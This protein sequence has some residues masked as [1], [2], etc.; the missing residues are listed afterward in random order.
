MRTTRRNALSLRGRETL[1]ALSAIAIVAFGLWIALGS[2]GREAPESARRENADRAIPESLEPNATADAGTERE[3]RTAPEPPALEEAGVPSQDAAGPPAEESASLQRRLKAAIELTLVG[4]LDPTAIVQA[5]S[6]LAQLHVAKENLPG[7]A[8]DGSLRYALTPC[9]RG[10]Q[11]EL[12]VARSSGSD[13][14][15]V[16]ALRMQLETPAEPYLVE[17]AVRKNPVAHVQMHL[18][19]EGRMKDLVILTDVAPSGRSGSFG[20][21]LGEGRIPQGILFHADMN[22]PSEWNAESYGLDGGADRSWDDPIA[23]LGDPWPESAGL[24]ELREG[25]LEL[26]SEARR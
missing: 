18:D 10:I 8:P 23:L 17:G 20:L 26:L 19:E 24:A 1:L 13:F 22:Q 11:A 6:S 3:T 25:L 7:T 15:N 4:A 14:E 2:R 16:I 21:P 12:W 5:A 9:P